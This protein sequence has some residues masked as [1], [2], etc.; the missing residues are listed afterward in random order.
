[1]QV[2]CRRNVRLWV[3]GLGTVGRWLLG[4]LDSKAARLARRYDVRF[5]V[6]GVANARG[7]FV[8]DAGGLDFAAVLEHLAAG[9]SIGEQPAVERWSSAI[10]GL[11]ATEA[12]V[13]VEV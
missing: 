7:G 2:V 12:D 6:T 13:L 8:F 1:M 9:G 11:R 5:A 4:V 10:E 3:V